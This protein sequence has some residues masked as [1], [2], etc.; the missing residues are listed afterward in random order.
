MLAVAAVVLAVAVFPVA[1]SVSGQHSFG[2]A[3]A[4]IVGESAC[5]DELTGDEVM[6]V[7]EFMNIAMGAEVST[8]S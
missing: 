7:P 4:A 6:C 1:V 8:C 5:Y 3:G 2:D